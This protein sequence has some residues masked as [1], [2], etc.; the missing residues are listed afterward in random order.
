MDNIEL[1]FGALSIDNCILK[2]EGY[3]FHE[4]LLAQ[5]SQFHS[6]PVKVVQTDIYSGQVFLERY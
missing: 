3:K 1:D 2:S 6:S 5:I 4:G